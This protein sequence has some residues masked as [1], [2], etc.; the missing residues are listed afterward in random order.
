L[1]RSDNMAKNKFK[2][3]MNEMPIENWKTAPLSNIKRLE[4]E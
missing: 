1:E 2:E 4:G 3:K